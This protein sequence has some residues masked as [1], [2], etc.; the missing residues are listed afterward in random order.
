[1]FFGILRTGMYIAHRSIDC[2]YAQPGF[3]KVNQR[4]FDSIYNLLPKRVYFL[5]K[6]PLY[7]YVS[8]GILGSLKKCKPQFLEWFWLIFVYGSSPGDWSPRLFFKYFIVSWGWY[9]PGWGIFHSPVSVS[10]VYCNNDC[11]LIW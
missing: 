4:L 7:L 3:S 5:R 1:M 11:H 2:R 6:I 10:I 9:W 8:V